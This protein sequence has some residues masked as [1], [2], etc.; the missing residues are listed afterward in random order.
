MKIII[1]CD[2]K[3]EGDKKAERMMEEHAS[4]LR[5][6]LPETAKRLG[7]KLP[8]KLVLRPMRVNRW[9]AAHV[10]LFTYTPPDQYSIALQMDRCL[11]AR[12]KGRFVIDHECAHLVDVFLNKNWLHNDSFNMAQVACCKVREALGKKGGANGKRNSGSKQRK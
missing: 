8:R 9:R 4:Y 1:K 7:F 3:W 5:H 12:D 10:G 11:E 6:I 2:G